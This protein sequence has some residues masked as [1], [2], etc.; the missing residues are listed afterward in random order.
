MRSVFG[1]IGQRVLCDPLVCNAIYERK[2]RMKLLTAFLALTAFTLAVSAFGQDESPS[3]SPSDQEKASA[4]VETTPEATKS[5]GTS[6][7]MPATSSAGEKKAPPSATATPSSKK[8]GAATE[9][10]K[11]GAET[12]AKPGKQMSAEAMI[13]DNESKWEAAI[14]SHDLAT[15]EAMV[16]SDFMGVSSKGKFVNKSGLMS[17]MKSDKDTYKSAKVEKM[18]VRS[19]DKDVA[20]VTG[21]AREKGTGKDGKAFDRTYLYTDTWVLRNGQWQCVASQVALRGQK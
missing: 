12:P 1:R 21:S 8:T 11:A 2:N 19:F 14:G 10:K 18:N 7:E 9:A 15:V 20:V 5:P 17:E 16:A 4:T 6:E 3:A 13:K